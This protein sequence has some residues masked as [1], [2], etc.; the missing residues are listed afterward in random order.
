[1]SLH[2]TGADGE[3]GTWAQAPLGQPR[4]AMCPRYRKDAG[5]FRS[6]LGSFRRLGVHWANDDFI[7][8]W[9]PSSLGLDHASLV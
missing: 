8:Q 3:Q 1:M 7:F 9:T 5:D 6:K 4:E 2:L